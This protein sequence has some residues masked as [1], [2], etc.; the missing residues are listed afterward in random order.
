MT[1]TN[2]LY[3]SHEIPNMDELKSTC[4]FICEFINQKVESEEQLKVTLNKKVIKYAVYSDMFGSFTMS[5]LDLFF[6]D[7]TQNE[8]NEIWHK[9]IQLQIIDDEGYFVNQ[10]Y[11]ETTRKQIKKTFGR[12]FERINFV[13]EE[14]CSRNRRIY[15]PQHLIPFIRLHL[16]QWIENALRSLTMENEKEYIVDLDRSGVSFD[17][18][19]VV[20]IQD[21]DTGTDQYNCKL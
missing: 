2:I 11:H 3:L 10:E 1:G 20:I 12:N 5:H 14:N 21:L 13:I 4:I 16:D 6:A 17:R 7:R 18:N 9:L 19:P 15:V 8:R